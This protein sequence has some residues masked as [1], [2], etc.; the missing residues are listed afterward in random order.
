MYHHHIVT[1]LKI[2]LKKSVPKTKKVTVLKDIG[3]EVYKMIFTFMGEVMHD[4]QF[5]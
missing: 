3:L 5:T 1:R 2:N 4:D